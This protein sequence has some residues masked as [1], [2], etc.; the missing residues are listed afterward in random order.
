MDEALAAKANGI[1]T[2]AI[3][4]ATIK[5]PLEEAKTEN[6]PVVNVAGLDCSE[7]L[8]ASAGPD[9]FTASVIPSAAYPTQGALA[10]AAAKA[11]VAWVIAATGGDAKLIDFSLTNLSVGIYA[12]NGVVQEMALCPRCVLYQ[13]PFTLTQFDPT[14]ITSLFQSALLKHPQANSVYALVNAVYFSGLAQAVVS[15]G[16]S[17]QAVSAGNEALAFEKVRTH[18]G[19]SAVLGEDFIWQGW[20]AADTLNRVFAGDPAVPEGLG[21]QLVDAT[22]NLPASGAFVA[23]VNYQKAYETVWNG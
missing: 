12:E 22:H 15:S 19:I 23:P 9:L 4:C 20:S 21:F 7:N 5:E 18:A 11:Q 16:K 17:L 3:D 13:V 2:N 6:V 10:L 8:P 1:I 14:D